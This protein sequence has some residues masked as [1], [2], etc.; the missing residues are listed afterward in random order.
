MDAAERPA[1]SASQELLDKGER[2]RAGE[3]LPLDRLL[4]WLRAHI[5]GLTGEPAITQ[6]PGGASNLTY[7]LRFPGHD[8]VLRRAPF[9]TKA[10]G[11]HDMA[12]EFRLQQALKPVYPLVP[13]VYALCETDDIIG[14][15]FY[16]MQRVPGIILRRE[17]PA[18][19]TLGPAAARELCTN[20][21]DALIQLHKVDYESAG[22]AS[23][24]KGTGFTRRQV[25]GWCERYSR[26]KTWNVPSGKQVMRWLDANTPGHETLSLTHNDFRFDNL[27][28]DIQAPTHIVAVLDWELATIGN[29]LMDLGNSLAYWIQ[30]DDDFVARLLRRQPTHLAGMLTRAEVLHYYAEKTGVSL[31]NFT[32]YEVFA[33]FRLAGIIQQIYYRYHH[34]QT[35][36]P[37][38]KRFWLFV[39]YLLWRCRRTIK[40]AQHTRLRP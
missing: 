12:R 13:D 20:A 1:L 40:R 14:A 33:H 8:L 32:F 39:N 3:E 11:A 4:P 38:F 16:V 22:L 9:G 18:T 34:G 6:F 25:D 37:A 31:D 5:A 35:R 23:L 17:M 26:A 19:L 21:L 27:V 24:A 2:P 29:P 28:L 15:R 7:Q 30:A 10:R 36:N